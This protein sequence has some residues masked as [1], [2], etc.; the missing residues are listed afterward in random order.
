MPAFSCYSDI[1]DLLLHAE[2]N[3]SEAWDRL[4]AEAE[5]AERVKMTEKQLEN[6]QSEPEGVEVNEIGALEQDRLLG[7]T[8]AHISTL[9]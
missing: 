2:D 7:E 6:H 3:H 1:E 4:I 5:D 8:T 9:R